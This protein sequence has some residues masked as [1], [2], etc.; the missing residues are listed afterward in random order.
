VEC[1]LPWTTGQ[2]KAAPLKDARAFFMVLQVGFSPE[3]S[4][5]LWA[6]SIDAPV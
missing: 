2:F 5:F 6:Q 4:S 1:G 3:L